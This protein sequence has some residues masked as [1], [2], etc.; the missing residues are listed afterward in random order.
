LTLVFRN[1]L[2]L[3]AGESELHMMINS[4]VLCKL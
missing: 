3:F 1:S 4:S 2:R